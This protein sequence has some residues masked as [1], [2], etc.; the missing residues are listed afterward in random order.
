MNAYLDH[1]APDA[2]VA[3]PGSFR[4]PAGGVVVH[5]DRVFR[6]LIGA[7]GSNTL[8]L[9]ESPWYQQL[10]DHGDVVASRPV[11]PAEAPQVYAM[12]SQITAVLEHPRI[13]FISYAYE[14]PF[15]MLRAAAQHQL[16]LTREAF[17]HGYIIK[18]ATPYNVQFDGARPVFID[19][20]SFERYEPGE[21]WRAYSQFCRLFLNPLYLQAYGVTAFQPMLRSSLD[22]LDTDVVRR[23]LPLRAKLRRSVFMDVVLQSI[24]NRRFGNN[25]RVLRSVA[26]K[27]ISDDMVRGMLARMTRTVEGIRRRRERSTWVNYAQT[28]SHYTD[29]GDAF[30]ESFVRRTLGNARPGSV[31]DLGCNTGQFSM[32]AAE[33]AERVV[34]VDSDEP[35]VDAL[36][37]QARSNGF[38]V[39]PLV[40]DLTN[41][42]PDQG[43]GQSE[44]RGFAS[45]GTADWALCLALI[46]HVSIA[47]NVPFGRFIDWV[48]SLARAAI[49]EF[50]PKDDPMVQRLLLTRKDVYPQYT[51]SHFEQAVTA[52]F[53]IV[54]RVAVPG[55]GRVLYALA[56][57]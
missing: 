6:Y 44:R 42:S 23:L 16:M 15:E 45:R 35:S 12:D 52:R 21:G 22:G 38:N 2:P 33:I 30:K 26:S 7:A 9:L 57:R 10:V 50:V 51:Q 4:D 27:K 54:D 19:I 55:G 36:F 8:T 24:L 25:E 1:S 41:P 56:R 37:R 3:E 48:A 31:L 20:P 11:R 40:M 43:W 47:G 18:D 46:H 39:L 28:K 49:I 34:A 5:G 14:W 13:D 32:I 17:D 53:S 29:E